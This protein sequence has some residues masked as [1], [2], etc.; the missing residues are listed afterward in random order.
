MPSPAP[1]LTVPTHRAEPFTGG[2]PVL[3]SDDP[4]IL[5]IGGG[6]AGSFFAIQALR[7]AR[8]AGRKLKVVIIEKKHELRFYPAANC[9]ACREGCNYCAGGIS[10][11]LARLLKESGLALPPEII[12][13]KATSLTVHGDWKSIELP[14]PPGKDMLFVFRGTRPRTR[15]ERYDNFDN[16]LLGRAIEEGAQV[17]TG[18]VKDIA[19]SP[20]DKP[21]VTYRVFDGV[22]ST[23]ATL[24]ADFVVV[25][26]GVNQLPGMELASNPLFAALARVIPG[27]Q[28]PRV[29]KA[30]IA[31]MAADEHLLRYMRDQVHFAQYGSDDLHIEM[32]SLIPKG[33]WITVALLGRSV[34]QAGPSEYL[35]VIERFLQ[36]PHIRRLLP[37]NVALVPGCVCHPNMTVGVARNPYGHRIGIIGDM[38]ISRLYKDG[39]LSAYVT[40]SALANCILDVGAD[41]RSL[42]RAYWPAIRAFHRDNKF[43]AVVFF[44][45]RFTFSHPVLS[46]IV[47]QAVVTERK[48]KPAD[49]RRLANILWRIASGDDSYGRIFLSMFHPETMRLI[50]VGGV[51]VTTRNY[52]TE[53]FFGLNWEGF[54]RY[55]TGVATEEVD[56]E[57]DTLAS[58][59][60][61]RTLRHAP[62]FERMYSIKIMADPIDILRELAKFGDRSR[63]YFNPRLLDVHRTSGRANKPGS[64]IRYDVTPSWLSFS[65]VLER[66]FGALPGVSR[67]GWLRPRGRAGLRHRSQGRRHVRSV[68]LRGV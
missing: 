58:L 22:A 26:A 15:T 10:P 52:L 13:G 57:R 17:I 20:A 21:L 46:R 45:N 44:L 60:D 14:V 25:A 1:P 40:A 39:I 54:G 19:Y 32:S 34:D 8:D 38:V 33:R 18:E 63:S 51:L 48:S 4:T 64:T 16:Y 67:A 7:K 42:R 56:R 53:R 12:L 28:P 27:F 6:P 3:L 2:T 23:S 61:L 43:G 55:P 24:E 29:R 5:V 66:S 49:T 11:K 30:L 59:L 9:T 68:D 31:E 36:L 41:R 35:S 47:Y 65:I 37:R 50:L 62:Q